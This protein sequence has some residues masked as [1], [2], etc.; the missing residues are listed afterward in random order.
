MEEISEEI[1][2]LWNLTLVDLI[3]F[4]S[5]CTSLY[6]LVSN[7]SHIKVRMR[8]RWNK[9]MERWVNVLW[10]V[11]L[12]YTKVIDVSALGKVHTLYLYGIQV[13]DISA[14]GNVHIIR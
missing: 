1:I 3:S 4:A 11:D 6:R 8:G 14:L 13:T 2:N 9:K 7:S 12:S 10:N 5:T